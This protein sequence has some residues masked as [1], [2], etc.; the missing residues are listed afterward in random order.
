[1]KENEKS[2]LLIESVVKGMMDT[3][4]GNI[5]NLD[6]SK[7]KNAICNHFIICD[8]SSN[9]QVESIADSVIG[10]VKKE[11]GINPVNKEGFENAEWILIDYFDVI[12]HIFQ[13]PLRDFYK[14]EN[15]W[16]DASIIRYDEK[17]YL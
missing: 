3:K 15:L 4:A 1:M 9:I 12:V 6:F 7:F 14:L 10:V 13:K 5:V 2:K 16:A 17:N 8:G 11:I